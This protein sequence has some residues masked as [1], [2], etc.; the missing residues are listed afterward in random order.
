MLSSSELDFIFLGTGPSSSLPLIHCVTQP[1]ESSQPP[2][3]A[4]LSTLNPHGRKN[5]RRNTG[6]V[7][8]ARR[9]DSADDAVIVID[10]GKTFIQAALEWFPR[11]GLRKIDAVIITHGHADG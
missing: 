8:R 6:A 11:Y 7:V 9:P 1:E 10:V 3:D 4:C 5:A 2:C